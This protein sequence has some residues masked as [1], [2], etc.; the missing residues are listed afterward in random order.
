M[1]VKARRIKT[2]M[3]SENS[4]SPG[5]CGAH[6]MNDELYSQLVRYLVEGIVP[7]GDELATWRQNIFKTARRHFEYENGRLYKLGRSFAPD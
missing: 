1:T 4:A 7:Q 6:R 5:R 2:P 3:H